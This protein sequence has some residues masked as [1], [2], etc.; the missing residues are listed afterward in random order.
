MV[1]AITIKV[2]PFAGAW[3]EIVSP[4]LA[5]TPLKVAPFAGAWI[6]IDNSKG[7]P[8]PSLRR[9]LRGSVD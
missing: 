8:T 5:R 1:I 9:S 6:E 3:I 4:I 7:N 2:A